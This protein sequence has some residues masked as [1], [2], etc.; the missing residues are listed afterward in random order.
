MK[1]RICKEIIECTITAAGIGF[2]AGI[3]VLLQYS[4]TCDV[5]IPL[6]LTGY[7]ATAGFAL[8]LGVSL[9][10]EVMYCI[11]NLYGQAKTLMEEEDAWEPQQ[12]PI[13]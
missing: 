7:G 13:F 5:T 1:K 12:P 9:I 8:G 2:L 3:D 4:N 6:V 10:N 11:E